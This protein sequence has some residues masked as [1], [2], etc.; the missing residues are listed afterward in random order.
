MKRTGWSG[1]KTY[2]KNHEKE[3]ANHFAA[4]EIDGGAGHP[5]GINFATKPEAKDVLRA[6]GEDFAKL[7]RRLLNFSRTRRRRG[8]RPADEKGR[9][10]I[11]PDPGQ[12]HLLSIITT[13][14][15]TRWIRLFR[16]NWPKTRRSS[17]SP[18]TRWRI[19]KSRCRASIIAACGILTFARTRRYYRREAVRRPRQRHQTLS[20]GKTETQVAF[21]HRC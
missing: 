12:P 11:Q 10:R 18:P 9:A 5:L 13:P 8:H 21:N 15:P 2:A 3:I 4:M 6:G 7:R 14:P 1:G 17:P 16:R 20:T 19:S